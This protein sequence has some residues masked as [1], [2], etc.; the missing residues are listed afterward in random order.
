MIRVSRTSRPVEKTWYE[1]ANRTNVFPVNQNES[2]MLG[3]NIMQ[4]NIKQLPKGPA[5]R[6]LNML[7]FEV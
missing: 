1:W 3:R 7:I 5:D 6:N 2:V 4:A